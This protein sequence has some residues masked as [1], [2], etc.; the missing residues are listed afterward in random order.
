MAMQAK[1]GAL[2]WVGNYNTHFSP[3]STKFLFILFISVPWFY[4]SYIKFLISYVHPR[5][6]KKFRYD[7]AK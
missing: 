6:L 1:Q 7:G 4:V 5:F 2:L 3:K